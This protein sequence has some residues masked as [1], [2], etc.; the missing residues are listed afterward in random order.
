MVLNGLIPQLHE[1]IANLEREKKAAEKKGQSIESF[2]KN[3]LLFGFYTS[4]L[5]GALFW[6]I[7]STTVFMSLEIL[8]FLLFF[9]F[10]AA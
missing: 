2:R 5:V 9:G 4:I 1:R 8:F 3:E 10:H 7:Y 6:R